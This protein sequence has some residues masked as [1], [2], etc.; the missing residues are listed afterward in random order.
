MILIFKKYFITDW[1]ILF[2]DV[3]Y[4]D[5][6]FPPLLRTLQHY[7]CTV[8]VQ[9][10]LACTVRDPNTLQKFLAQLGMCVR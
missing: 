7:L 4:D 10:V 3:V 2:S 1:Y 6:I 8:Q 5:T 9:A